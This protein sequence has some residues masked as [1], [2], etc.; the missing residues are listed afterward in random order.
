MGTEE[1]LKE[2][3]AKDSE[4]VNASHLRALHVS[5]DHFAPLLIKVT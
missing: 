2:K 5:L 1:N 3:S 4:L